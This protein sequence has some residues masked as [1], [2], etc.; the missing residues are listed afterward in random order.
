MRRY[1]HA[2]NV[3]LTNFHKQG[4][5]QIAYVQLLARLLAE[6]GHGVTIVAPAGS[7]LAGRAKAAGLDVADGFRFPRGFRPID[8]A[9]DVLAARRLFRDRRPDIIHANGSQDHWVMAAARN[10]FRCPA[11]IVRTKHNSFPMRTHLSN[12]LLARRLTHR[13]IVVS[14]AVRQDMLAGALFAEPTI[15]TIHNG[16]DITQY[17]PRDGRSIRAEFGLGPD[18]V[19]IGTLGRL[20]K[21]KGHRYLFDAVA[22]LV[23]RPR[24]NLRLLLVGWGEEVDI[25]KAQAEEL[26]IADAI[27]YAGL[28]DDVPRMISMFDIGVQASIDC[29]SSSFAMKE[30]MAMAVPCVCTDFAGNA[31][32]VDHERNGLVVPPADSDALREGIERLWHDDALRREFGVK[33]RE[34]IRTRF[35][36]DACVEQTLETY[37]KA[38]AAAGHTDSG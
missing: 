30:I 8:F 33:A 32:I 17:E 20:T 19:V 12:R 24:S 9:R 37:R 16:L 4:F 5:G 23:R 31:E 21:A 1:N 29:E 26:G 22:P 6:R 15:D 34:C 36:A 28:Q 11:A 18:D 10:L 2:M 38:M 35:S 3:L 14:E 25:L 7:W 27:V 13:W